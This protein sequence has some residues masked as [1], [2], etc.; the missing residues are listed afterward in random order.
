MYINQAYDVFW[1]IPIQIKDRCPKTAWKTRRML[2]FYFLATSYTT[3]KEAAVGS[4]WTAI[5]T[6]RSLTRPLSH[7][8]K[9]L[10][11][12]TIS[13]LSHLA[14]D[15]QMR[16]LKMTMLFFFFLIAVPHGNQQVSR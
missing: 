2:A 6:R 5:P 8:R 13:P 9:I 4:W 3:I 1:C 15:V 12:R 14:A 10:T 7:C 16:A 11:Q